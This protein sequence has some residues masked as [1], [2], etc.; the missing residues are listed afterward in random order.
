MATFFRAGAR[1]SRRR[2]IDSPWPKRRIIGEWLEQRTLLSANLSFAIAGPGPNAEQAPA[3]RTDAAGNVYELATDAVYKFS[4][5]GAQIWSAPYTANSQI[6]Q[7]EGLAVDSQGDVYIT[8]N[9][10]NL[11]GSPAKFGGITLS[12]AGVVDGYLAK[13]DGSGNF[14][15]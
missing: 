2:Q 6:S 14:L 7:K 4:A 1:L 9:F 10:S 12:V 15:W 5:A 3:V 8:G 11:A 13:L